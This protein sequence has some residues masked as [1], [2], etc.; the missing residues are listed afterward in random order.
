MIGGNDVSR[1]ED[2]SVKT[3]FSLTLPNEGTIKANVEK[4]MQDEA[5]REVLPSAFQ[6][7]ESVRV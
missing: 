6:I 1:T 5:E 7:H 2:I 3:L 4:Q